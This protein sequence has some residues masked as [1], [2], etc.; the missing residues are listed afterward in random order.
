MA[1]ILDSEKNRFIHCSRI[2]WAQFKFRRAK[3]LGGHSFTD[4]SKYNK[5]SLAVESVQYIADFGMTLLSNPDISA[6]NICLFLN[7]MAV[8]ILEKEVYDD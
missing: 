3:C 4:C 1:Q 6:S 2:A 5:F 7:N 8:A